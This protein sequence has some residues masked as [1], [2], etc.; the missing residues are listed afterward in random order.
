MPKEITHLIVAD[1]VLSALPKQESRELIRNRHLYDL[2]STA[3]DLFYYDLPFPFE[4]LASTEIFSERIH[5][6]SG[7]D[8]MA[9]VLWMLG[10]LKERPVEGG[11]AFIAGYL[12][13]TASDAVFHPMVYSMTGNYY[14]EDAQERKRSRARHRVLETSLDLYLLERRGMSI[15]QFDLP[16]RCRPQRGDLEI[17]TN[18]YARSLRVTFDPEFP[19]EA[20]IRRALY[21]SRLM[22]RFMVSKII[23]RLLWGANRLLSFRMNDFVNLFYPPKRSAIAFETRAKTPHPVTGRPY[24]RSV[25]KLMK[26]SVKNAVHSIRSARAYLEGRISRRQI[27]KILAPFSL[28]NGL[29][30]T[31]VSAMKH[32]KILEG[33]ER[34]DDR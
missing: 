32:F 23:T 7:E 18:L 29:V 22:I 31:P 16:S 19:L 4:V 17:L 10:E 13:H 21:K 15:D 26:A 5:G 14:A 25:E 3:P 8:N 9:H 2:G 20:G 30:Q 6:K 34:F 1:E 33:I 28:N 27:E 11:F 12:T 24:N